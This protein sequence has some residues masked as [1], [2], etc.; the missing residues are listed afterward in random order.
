MAVQQPQKPQR[1]RH[2]KHTVGELVTGW[3][4][5]LWG[6]AIVWI[7]FPKSGW[8]APLSLKTLTRLIFVQ[9]VCSILSG[10]LT[11]VRVRRGAQ[12][13]LG[14]ISLC[15]LGM[16]GVVIWIVWEQNAHQLPYS[17]FAFVGAGLLIAFGFF[18]LGRWLGMQEDS[19]D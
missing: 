1:R 14:L 8:V 12:W 9:G 3:L 16:S 4:L 2:S 6:V 17:L 18:F 15:F 5:L 10:F 11:L 7:V 13:L 19:A